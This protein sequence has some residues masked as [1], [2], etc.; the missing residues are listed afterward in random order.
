MPI[1]F[2]DIDLLAEVL[3]PEEGRVVD[4]ESEKLLFLNPA[5]P[6]QR[7]KLQKW[8]DMFQR[9]VA[10]SEG[11]CIDCRNSPLRVMANVSQQV[12]DRYEED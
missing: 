6:E 10:Y 3:S 1:N 2:K 8:I 9:E 11:D 12:I 5:I 4:Q 7:A